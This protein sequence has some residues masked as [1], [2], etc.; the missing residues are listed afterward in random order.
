MA[1]AALRLC[2][3]RVRLIHGALHIGDLLARIGYVIVKIPLGRAGTVICVNCLIIRLLRAVLRSV[4]GS[5]LRRSVCLRGLYRITERDVIIADETGH[6]LIR[7]GRI[8]LIPDI[9]VRILCLSDGHERRACSQLTDL[10]VICAGAGAYI[11]IRRNRGVRRGHCLRISL[12]LCRGN[13]RGGS[14]I[15]RLRCIRSVCRRVSGGISGRISRRIRCCGVCRG[16]SCVSG[17]RRC[18][19]NI[20]EI[21]FDIPC[22]AVGKRHRIPRLARIIGDRV[23]DLDRRILGCLRHCTG[24]CRCLGADI[25]GVKDRCRCSKSCN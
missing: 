19:L 3:E 10:G 4:L 18:L 1:D 7:S 2:H 11:D 14:G 17:S 20:Q 15:R 23:T 9:A 21:G 25:A 22:R 12:A 24:R 13:I 8:E 5:V 6:L 16:C